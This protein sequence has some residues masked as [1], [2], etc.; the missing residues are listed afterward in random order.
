MR[1]FRHNDI[2]DLER[3]LAGCSPTAGRLVVVDGVFSMS[4]EIA[5]LREIVEC[6][7]AHGAR[8]LVDDAHGIGVTGDGHGTA[9]HHG[10]TE[11]VDLIMGTFS[12]S[13][14]SVGGFVAGDEAAIH[15]IQHRARSLIFSASLPP[16]SAAAALAALDVLEKEPE[17]VERV[18]TIAARM[19]RSLGALGFNTGSGET[20]IVPITVGG[21]METLVLWKTLLEA[22]VYTNAA[23]PPAVPEGRCLLR[24]SYMATHTDDQL[25]TVLQAF[26][27]IQHAGAGL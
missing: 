26:S 4:G 16:A 12:K 19:R 22:G 10:V 13:L 15:W 21:A 6:C 3:V 18:N 23:L 8:L 24:T 5:P 9:A 17:R 1:R 2:A 27:S 7:R 25:D 14:A 20:P 11:G